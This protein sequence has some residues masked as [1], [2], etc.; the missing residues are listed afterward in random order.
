MQPEVGD[1][2]ATLRQVSQRV[3]TATERE[4]VVDED[5][6]EGE[7]ILFNMPNVPY[8][9]ENKKM[10]KI[11]GSVQVAS[12]WSGTVMSSSGLIPLKLQC[13]RLKSSSN[14]QRERF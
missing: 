9:R 11:T 1:A 6:T 12:A 7:P 14:G 4:S 5:L 2:D 10:V 13:V 8:D 3:T